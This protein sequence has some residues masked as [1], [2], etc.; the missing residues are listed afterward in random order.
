M[1]LCL[2]I[3]GK[4]TAVGM[5]SGLI[6]PTAGDCTIMGHSMLTSAP[7]ARQCLGFCPQQNILFGRL[8]AREHLLLY[9]AIKGLPRG[10][11]GAAA[12]EAA[13]AMLQV[14]HSC[15]LNC[16]LVDDNL[17]AV[18]E[19]GMQQLRAGKSVNVRRSP[20]GDGR[21]TTLIILPVH[22]SL[23]STVPHPHPHP[24]L[25]SNV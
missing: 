25:F 14:S 24:P 16:K 11:G 18:L 8:T 10:C 15:V 13:D 9:S 3:A 6:R 17:C 7:L 21:L 19:L 4:T 2:T 23:Q 12:L 1:T 5:L 20:S 22:R